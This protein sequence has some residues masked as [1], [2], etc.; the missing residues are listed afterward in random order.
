MLRLKVSVETDEQHDDADA[1]KGCA[2][3]LAQ[4]ADP[5]LRGVRKDGVFGGVC[6]EGQDGGPF[7]LVVVCERGV[8]AE[9]LGY[10]YA[11]AG[12]GERGAEPGEEG[13]LWK[14]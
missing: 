7:L 12:K 5:G 3:R 8:E 2:E 1:D 14:G 4:M 11:D 10:C 9:E 6:V 13:A